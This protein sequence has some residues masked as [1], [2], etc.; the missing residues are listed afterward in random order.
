MHHLVRVSKTN[1]VMSRHDPDFV[2][3]LTPAAVTSATTSSAS[4]PVCDAP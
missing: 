3:A 2:H 4:M 1:R